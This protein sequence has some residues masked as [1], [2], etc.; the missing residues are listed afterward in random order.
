MRNILIYDNEVL[1]GLTSN[2][3]WSLIMPDNLTC[4]VKMWI[5]SSKTWWIKYFPG[6]WGVSDACLPVRNSYAGV[7]WYEEMNVNIFPSDHILL[8]SKPTQTAWHYIILCLQICFHITFFARKKKSLFDLPHKIPSEPRSC[9]LCPVS[10]KYYW[11]PFH[12]TLQSKARFQWE[13]LAWD[14]RGENHIS[15]SMDSCVSLSDHLASSH[16]Q[17][18]I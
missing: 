10:I 18:A 9:G 15:G 8:F 16:L 4:R 5:S 1:M 3:A 14:F 13:A 11:K 6:Q 12:L 7:K 17:D 2:E